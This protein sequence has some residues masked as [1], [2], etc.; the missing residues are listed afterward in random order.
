M[1]RA[2]GSSGGSSGGL[3]GGHSFGGSRAGGHSF[4]GSSRAGSGSHRSTSSSFSSSSSSHRS[5]SSSSRLLNEVARGAAREVGRQIVRNSTS[6]STGSRPNYNNYNSN[7]SGMSGF[8][9]SYSSPTYQ[10]D[11]TGLITAIIE[12][13]IAIVVIFMAF[14]AFSGGSD[15]SIKSTIQREKLTGTS[16]NANSVII[17]DELGYIDSAS[18]LGK[19]LK[20]F[21]TDTGVQPYIYIKA[22]D[23]SLT[24]NTA[25][26]N[27][28]QQF[29]DSQIADTNGFMFIYFGSADDANNNIPDS[30][31]EIGYM[32][33]VVGGAAGSVMD[34]EACEIFW[35]YVDKYWTSDM[36]TEDMFGTVFSKTANS[37]MK[38]DKTDKQ[39]GMTMV[40]VLAGLGIGVVAVVLVSKKFKRQ[41]MDFKPTILN[42]LSI[43]RV[44]HM[45]SVAE[46]MYKFCHKFK[47]IEL[48]PEE[49][50]LLGLNHD[51]GYI[52]CGPHEMNGRVLFLGLGDSYKMSII[53][54]C[55]GFHG[56]TPAQYMETKKL[57]E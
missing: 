55:I 38:V 35:S 9:S 19:E 28:A 53:S 7:Y 56:Y 42:K 23:P 31:K 16:Y 37:I 15:S 44:K 17:G 39:T 51:I 46:L 36:S 50:Y 41:Y 12:F 11:N 33:Y 29:Y 30:Q 13:I 54:E 48:R 4:G 18:K 3:G 52:N 49:C 8:G 47:R 6:S 27:W 10:S 32:S 24:S 25:K 5:T 1:G 22:Y 43:E 20:K 34:N 57:M 40:I 14:G 21:Y 2:G 45:H 26:T